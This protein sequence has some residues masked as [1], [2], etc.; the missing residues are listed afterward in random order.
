MD[1]R[2]AAARLWVDGLIDP[3]QT[4][5]VVVGELRRR[6]L[7]PRA[8]GVQDRRAADLMSETPSWS[9]QFRP[10]ARRQLE[11][12]DR[13]VARRIAA[14]LHWLTENAPELRH[15]PLRFEL[16]GLYKLRVG[17]WR[18]IYRLL[19]EE[20]VVLVVRLGHRSEVYDE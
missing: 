7:Q 5:E 10:N 20:R 1:P 6:R 11:Q 16:E 14:R 15:L 12:T 9:L 19:K 3:A 8:P 4:R 17:D 2:Y 18:V 13:A